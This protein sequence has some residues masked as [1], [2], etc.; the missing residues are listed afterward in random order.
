[1]R[2][3][4]PLPPEAVVLHLELVVKPEY[5]AEFLE[6]LWA[7]AN[8]AL[9]NEEGCL[10]FDVTVDSEDPN[11]ILLYEVYRD[12]AARTI[13]R[14]APYLKPIAAGLDTWLATPS[15]MFVSVVQDPAER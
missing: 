4:D 14:A 1:V 2:P 15:K 11:R 6:A 10:R 5:R 13:H 3:V 8:G 7:D 9:D 12:A